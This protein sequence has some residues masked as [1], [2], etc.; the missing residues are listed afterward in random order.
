MFVCFHRR[1]V[2]KVPLTSEV[3]VVGRHHQQLRLGVLDDV[4]PVDGVGVAQELVLVNVD[5][6]VED[7]WEEKPKK[8]RG[9]NEYECIDCAAA[10]AGR[11]DSSRLTP[12]V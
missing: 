4:T 1:Y 2:R 10:A 6:P 8:K 3:A 12:I 7:L 11:I 9:R 5:A